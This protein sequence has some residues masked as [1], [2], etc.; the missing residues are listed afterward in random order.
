[1]IMLN[2]RSRLQAGAGMA[3]AGMARVA[4]RACDEEARSSAGLG[5]KGGTVTR[6]PL[7][8]S[9]AMSSK[10]R[11]AEQPVHALPPTHLKRCVPHE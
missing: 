4:G 10:R 2:S 1:M 3:R 11:S 9:A 7:T 6:Q 5:H 8:G